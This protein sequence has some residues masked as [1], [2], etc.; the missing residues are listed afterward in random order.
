MEVG[1]FGLWVHTPRRGNMYMHMHTLE[2]M[3]M[4]RLELMSMHM[5]GRSFEGR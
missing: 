2:L 1:A 4:T 3:S 5:S